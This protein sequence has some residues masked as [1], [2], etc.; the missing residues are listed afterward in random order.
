MHLETAPPLA[1]LTAPPDGS[2]AAAAPSSSPADE[3]QPPNW[4]PLPVAKVLEYARRRL[5]SLFRHRCE[6]DREDAL[7]QAALAAVRQGWLQLPKSVIYLS[8]H[9]ARILCGGSTDRGKWRRCGSPA[10]SRAGHGL[11]LPGR[12]GDDADVVDPGTWIALVTEAPGDLAADAG[13]WAEALAEHEA[14]PGR[15]PAAIAGRTAAATVAELRRRGWT[16]AELEDR[17]QARESDLIRYERGA[18]CGP[19]VRRRLAALLREPGPLDDFRR[20]LAAARRE[21]H[22]FQSI[23]RAC[24]VSKEAASRWYQG[25]APLPARR[26]HLCAV[27]R[28]LVEAPPAPAA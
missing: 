2:A 5:A 22:S 4:R 17:A 18:P 11:R 24:G 1:D 10:V 6:D 13:L 27:L 25:A 19:A 26:P 15:V 12:R 8:G 28:A 20:L 21:G 9:A 16:L 14:D 3:P 7:Q 23:G